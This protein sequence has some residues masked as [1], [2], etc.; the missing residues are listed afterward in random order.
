MH[1]NQNNTIKNLLY[2]F[3]IESRRNMV[4]AKWYFYFYSDH[5]W[6]AD[7]CGSHYFVLE[8]MFDLFHLD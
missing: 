6:N 7:V 8:E 4:I 2:C 5:V 1:I 3:N